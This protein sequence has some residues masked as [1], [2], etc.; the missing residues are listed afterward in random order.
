MKPTALLLFLLCSF[1]LQAQALTESNAPSL[2]DV[3]GTAELEIVPDLIYLSIELVDDLKNERP[4]DQQEKE[5]KKAL[6]DL[7]VELKNLSLSN[8]NA[9]YV[10]V[11]FLKKDVIKKASYT[12]LLNRADQLGTVFSKLD[13]LK[14]HRAFIS[15]LD[16]SNRLEI[17]KQLRVNAIK[18]AKEK[19]DYLLEAINEKTGKAVYVNED[20]YNPF[21]RILHNQ[22]S[23]MVSDYGKPDHLGALSFEVIKLKSSIH[24]KFTIL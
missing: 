5:M 18:A 16:H 19:A 2:I 1:G 14:I 21:S 9:D 23:R 7:G 24:V 15:K 22:S 17:Q 13:E 6:S 11:G 10:R 4:I 8:T 12:L 3:T 20:V